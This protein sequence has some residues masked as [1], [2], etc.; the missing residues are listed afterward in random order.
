MTTAAVHPPVPFRSTVASEWIKLRTLRSMWVTVIVGSAIGIGLTAL[1]AGLAGAT[2]RE[3]PPDE[4]SGFEPV[5]FSLIGTIAPGIAVVVVAVK[6]VTSEYTTGMAA[7]TMTVTPRRERVL[8]A[9]LVVIGAVTLVV[10]TATNLACFLVGQAIFASA[11]LPSASLSDAGT[12]RLLVVASLVAPLIPFLGAALAVVIRGTAGAVTVTLALIMLPSFLGPLLPSWWQRNV[13]AYL[14]GPA[15]D[16][17]AFGDLAGV[18]M[19][20]PAWAS[21]TALVLWIVLFGAVAFTTLLR[22]DV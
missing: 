11:G 15:S 1:V 7:L 13:L 20:R 10:A 9:K 12:A 4:L 16:S 17:L 19:Y 6:A 14:P 21:A 8:A 2:W 18:P 22:R 3:W 5:L